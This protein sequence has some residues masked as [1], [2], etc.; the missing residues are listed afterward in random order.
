[1]SDDDLFSQIFVDPDEAGEDVE[2]RL[3][4]QGLR[5]GSLP[6]DAFLA[7]IPGGS[8]GRIAHV[9]E[10]HYRTW[11]GPRG[12]IVVFEL[13]GVDAGLSGMIARDAARVLHRHWP[14][15]HH[16]IALFQRHEPRPQGALY[17][18]LHGQM[19]VLSGYYR[20][21][22]TELIFGSSW[23]EGGRPDV[24][25]ILIRGVEEPYVRRK[26]AYVR[27]HLSVDPTKAE[28]ARQR[29]RAGKPLY[30]PHV[31]ATRSAGEDG[32]EGRQTSADAPPASA[33][34][35]ASKRRYPREMLRHYA[36]LHVE[37]GT[38]LAQ[39]EVAYR[40]LMKNGGH[41]DVGGTTASARTLIDA[42]TYMR[43]N[44]PVFGLGTTA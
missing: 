24:R 26:V 37:P 12:R 15:Q 38:S 25:D 36:A 19:L 13:L 9:G 3:A 1:M 33:R 30:R 4:E 17:I 32:G 2:R 27:G 22:I 42:I 20:E 21:S 39:C 34:I 7:G 6:F 16:P 40:A 8:D 35:D 14:A 41:P 43:D 31:R 5:K 44:L 28:T 11:S 29:R 18:P 10:I 23:L